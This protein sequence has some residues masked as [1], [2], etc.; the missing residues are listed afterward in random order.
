MDLLHT[1]RTIRVG[2]TLTAVVIAYDVIRASK[3][4]TM[5]LAVVAGIVIVGIAIHM[6]MLDLK[7]EKVVERINDYADELGPGPHVDA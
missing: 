6:K 5:F 3:T 2:V 1:L 7:A 4:L